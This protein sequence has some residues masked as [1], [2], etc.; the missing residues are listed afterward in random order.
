M[1]PSLAMISHIA[2]NS[3]GFKNRLDKHC[4]NGTTLSICILNL[5]VLSSDMIFFIQQLNIGFKNCKM[6]YR[7]CNVL[8]N[9]LSLNAC[10]LRIIRIVD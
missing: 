1:E 4:P 2:R 10:R 3:F 6:I 7:Y 9:N 5:Y 8:I